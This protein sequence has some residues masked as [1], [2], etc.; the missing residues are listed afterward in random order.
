MFEYLGWLSR[1]RRNSRLLCG[2]NY[3]NIRI[4]LLRMFEY[5]VWL[6]RRRRNN[7]LLCGCNYV[8]ICIILLRM[9]EYLGWLSRR[10]RNEMTQLLKILAGSNRAKFSSI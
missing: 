5:L 3:V 7:R 2:R 8:N 10:R 9:F 1:R 6:S 4:I